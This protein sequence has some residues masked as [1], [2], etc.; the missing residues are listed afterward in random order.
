MDTEASSLL[1]AVTDTADTQDMDTAAAAMDTEAPSLL[2]AVTDTDTAD[3][4]DMDMVAELDMV[5]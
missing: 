5:A 2:E 1:E 4:Q 3:T